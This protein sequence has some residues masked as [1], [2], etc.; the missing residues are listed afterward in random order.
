MDATA[1]VA[2]AG[3][4]IALLGFLWWASK[5]SQGTR[6]GFLRIS[7]R[8]FGKQI[9]SARLAVLARTQLTPHH[10]LHLIQAMEEFILLCTHP[11]GSSVVLS[12]PAGL[13]S[14]DEGS[15]EGQQ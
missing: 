13:A 5:K 4:V 10:Q 12:K 8:T 1:Q 6:L 15:G 11:G 3:A 9:D 14:R 7:P 2:A